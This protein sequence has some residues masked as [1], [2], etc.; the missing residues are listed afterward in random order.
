MSLTELHYSEFGV[1]I[2]ISL[3]AIGI[4]A[5]LHVAWPIIAIIT[6]GIWLFNFWPILMHQQED[7]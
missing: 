6:G 4:M 7:G 3:L 5:L 2:G 1:A